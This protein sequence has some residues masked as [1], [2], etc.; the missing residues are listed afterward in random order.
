M[1]LNITVFAAASLNTIFKMLLQNGWK[2]PGTA[3]VEQ[4]YSEQSS[5]PYHFRD[6]GHFWLAAK[7]VLLVKIAGCYA[8]VMLWTTFETAFKLLLNKSERYTEAYSYYAN[9]NGLVVKTQR[10]QSPSELFFKSMFRKRSV[11]I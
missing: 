9:I 1:H 10:S 8:N 2:F 7:C 6:S 4:S 5:L 11:E 3:Y